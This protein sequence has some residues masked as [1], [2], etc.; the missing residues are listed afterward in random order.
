MFLTYCFFRDRNL[1]L[2]SWKLSG[3][4]LSPALTKIEFD[5]F[6]KSDNLLRKL[7]GS[8]ILFN[9]IELLSMRIFLFLI[10]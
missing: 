6:A 9:I 8:K 4:Y 3:V 1:K 2:T 5:D 7:F 10:R